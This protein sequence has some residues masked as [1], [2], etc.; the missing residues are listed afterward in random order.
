M[1][2]KLKEALP[3]IDPLYLPL[4]TALPVGGWLLVADHNWQSTYLALY[5]LIIMFLIFS[6]SV[7]ISSE[8]GKHQIFGYIYMTSG[9]ILSAAGLIRWLF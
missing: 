1:L 8:E 6:G 9:L 4:Y 5:I 3:D 2:K 7:E